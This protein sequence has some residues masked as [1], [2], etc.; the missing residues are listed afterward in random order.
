MCGGRAGRSKGLAISERQPRGLRRTSEVIKAATVRDAMRGGVDCVGENEPVAAAARRLAELDVGSMP[1][2][3]ED[4][5]LKG[6]IPDRDIAVEVVAKS[7]DPQTTTVGS[8]AQGK[9][10]TIGADDSRDE[11]LR[12]MSEHRVRPLPVIDRHRLVGILSQAGLA[13]ALPDEQAGD[14]VH[15][16]SQ[17]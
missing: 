11:A 1:I 16:L 5:R 7:L 9:P 2:C 15:A 10:V 8:L 6:K 4:D 17:D 12:A 14:V 3:G 13:E